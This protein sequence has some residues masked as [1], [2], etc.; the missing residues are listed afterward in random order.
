MKQE[1]LEEKK[2]KYID[3]P[4]KE[5]AKYILKILNKKGIN[6]EH[7]MNIDSISKPMVMLFIFNKRKKCLKYSENKLDLNYYEKK[8]DYTFFKIDLKDYLT[9]K[10]YKVATLLYIGE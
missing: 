4:N 5:F 2:V 1:R 10:Q 9:K 6:F 8:H 3:I 7:P